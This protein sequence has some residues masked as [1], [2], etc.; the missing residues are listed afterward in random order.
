MINQCLLLGREYKDA[1][2]VSGWIRTAWHHFVSAFFSTCMFFSTWVRTVLCDLSSK[3]GLINYVKPSFLIDFRMTSL[4]IYNGRPDLEAN[5]LVWAFYATQTSLNLIRN[6]ILLHLFWNKILLSLTQLVAHW[7]I[8]PMSMIFVG[9][10]DLW[11][12]IL[13]ESSWHLQYILQQLEQIDWADFIN[14]WCIICI[15]II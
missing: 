9:N 1:C 5:K 13:F 8:K 11:H 2:P 6:E 7:Y 3:T 15:V 12:N 14:C 4:G 10:K